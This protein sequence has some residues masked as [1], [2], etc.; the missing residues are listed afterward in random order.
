MFEF[1]E[2]QGKIIN[3]LIL[4]HKGVVNKIFCHP[5]NETIFYTSFSEC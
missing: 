2:E 1:D 5:T 3:N 4:L